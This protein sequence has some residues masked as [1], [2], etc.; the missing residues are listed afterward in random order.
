MAKL[1]QRNPTTLP[2]FPVLAESEGPALLAECA[3]TYAGLAGWKRRAT[4]IRQGILRG[5]GLKRLPDKCPLS[6][7]VHSR[8]KY[9]G[10]SVE[11]VAFESLPGFFVTGSLY[12]PLRARK[13]P[14]G[15]LCPHG[16][17]AVGR[18]DPDLQA[19]HAR[20]ARMGAV[21]FAYDMVGYNDSTQTTH[22]DPN[23]VSIQLWN[24]IRALDFLLEVCGCDP[25][26]IG[27]TGASGGGTQTF[28]LTAVDSRVT[29][30]APVVMV[31]AHFFGGCKCESGKP[32]HKDP[33]TNN[34]EIAAL[35]APRPQL[36]VSCG[37]D[38]TKNTPNVE[39]PHIRSVY[40][41]YGCEDALEHAHF[42]LEQHDYG[43][44]KWQAVYEFF[45]RRLGLNRDATIEQG[46]TTVPEQVT[47]EDG[48]MLK[49]WTDAHPRPGDA[50]QGTEQ[51]ARALFGA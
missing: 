39:A 41:L 46:G 18:L 36:L 20:I 32:I 38:W 28:L 8:R 5:A 14:A 19:L 50:L 48:A 44:N 6:P 17:C 21:A 45:A 34:A 49:V 16:H 23:A 37:G 29:C 10:Y 27:V 2:G 31:S 7:I 9:E 33:P 11:N 35:A 40:R 25:D 51:I 4:R 30:S 12:R 24:S 15:V 43:P 13:P 3:A 26:R 47:I 1:E 42:P 22:A